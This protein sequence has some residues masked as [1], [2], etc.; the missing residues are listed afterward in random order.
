MPIIP[1]KQG[2]GQEKEIKYRKLRAEEERHKMSL[3]PKL[4]LKQ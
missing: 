1:V 3:P 2:G 4:N